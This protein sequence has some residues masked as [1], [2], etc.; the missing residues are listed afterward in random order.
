MHVNENESGF[1]LYLRLI[2]DASQI[3]CIET[4]K[5]ASWPLFFLYSVCVY[6]T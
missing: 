2:L 6:E 5:A 4:E 3:N 1:L